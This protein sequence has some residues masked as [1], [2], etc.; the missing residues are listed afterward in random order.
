MYP[1]CHWPE[2]DP[3]VRTPAQSS[4][5]GFADACADVR[6]PGPKVRTHTQFARISHEEAITSAGGHVR[7]RWLDRDLYLDSD[8]E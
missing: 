6:E 3:H 8:P 7:K 1:I 2:P 4:R 5:V